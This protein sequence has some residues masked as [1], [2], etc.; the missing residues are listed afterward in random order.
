[1]SRTRATGGDRAAVGTSP[2]SRSILPRPAR[3]RQ[4]RAVAPASCEDDATLTTALPPLCFVVMPFGVK[5]DGRGGSIDFDAVYEKLIAP[6][7]AEAK[8][9][10]LRGD[11]EHIGGM[12]HKPMFERLILSDYAVADL[13]TANANVFYELGVRHAVRPSHHGPDRRR[14]GPHPFDLAPDR[15]RPYTLDSRGSPHGGA[16]GAAEP[17]DR[18]RPGARAV[19]RQ[20]R[21][22]PRRW[23]ADAPDRSRQDRCLPRPGGLFGGRQA[24][25]GRRAPPGRG[26]ASG[27]GG[28]ARSRSRTWRPGWSSTC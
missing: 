14:P 15:V 22:Q 12:V 1:M 21:V 4:G 28:P 6:A 16:R 27:G 23:P 3:A 18:S 24:A 17:G 20:P 8:L 9:Q 11:Q 26:G 19:H 2:A 13:T 7:I 10:P 5:P 25:L